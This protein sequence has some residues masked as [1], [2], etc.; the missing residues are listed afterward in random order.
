M[1][2]WHQPFTSL[3][4]CLSKKVYAYGQI[5]LK[6]SPYKTMKNSRKKKS[7]A[8]QKAE[9][10]AKKLRNQSFMGDYLKLVDKVSTSI[11]KFM[12]AFGRDIIDLSGTGDQGKLD[13]F[14][15]EDVME[16]NIVGISRKG[17]IMFSNATSVS[18][19]RLIIDG[20]VSLE[21]AIGLEEE[22]RRAMS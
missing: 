9:R 3:L 4:T 16:K 20:D 17:Y 19:R 22:L 5:F 14:A 13:F 8:Y 18:L 2:N 1:K 21:D 12:G 6:V 15:N 11:D 7:T 10:T